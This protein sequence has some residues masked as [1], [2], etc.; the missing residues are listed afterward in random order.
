M[1]NPVK[2]KTI[3]RFYS[4]A[5]GGSWTYTD[6]SAVIWGAKDTPTRF[7]IRFPTYY[8]NNFVGFRIVRNK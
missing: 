3:D 7:G 1:K 6:W 5:R 2:E 8:H 4:V